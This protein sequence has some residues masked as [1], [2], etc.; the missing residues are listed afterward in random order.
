MGWLTWGLIAGVIYSVV[1]TAMDVELLPA[2]GSL[3]FNALHRFLNMITP[4]VAG[5]VVGV[6]FAYMRQRDARISAERRVTDALR[7]RLKGAE[8]Q[9]AV[10]LVASSLLHDVRNPLHALGL[11]LDEAADS[12]ETQQARQ[13][14]DRARTQADRIEQKIRSLREVAE[15]PPR[16]RVRLEIAALID[17]LVADLREVA[18]R[19]NVSI[20]TG[21]IPQ[22]E[23]EADERYV[24]TPLENLVMN[25][26]RAAASNANPLVRIEVELTER[27]LHVVVRDNG[28]G[29]PEE[30]VNALFE[31]LH[32]SK[33]MGLGLGLPLARALARL[34]G[35]DVRLLHNGP[36]Q[37][38]F[39]L[40][41]PL[42]EGPKR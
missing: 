22:V 4:P 37:T 1:D 6:L 38:A 17:A 2:G 30:I 35:G 23:V 16:E 8:R 9:Q 34:E 20:E 10:W 25:A 29:I 13:A 39:A 15:S 27:E 11:L 31:P 26:I 19:S 33:H 18:S 28:P 3:V 7:E 5:M 36:P 24:R 40:A 14:L 42:P 32:A 41:L 21:K 12:K